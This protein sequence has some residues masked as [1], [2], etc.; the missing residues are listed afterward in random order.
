[1]AVIAQRDSAEV[2]G[3]LGQAH[4]LARMVGGGGCRLLAAEN[5]AVDAGNAPDQFKVLLG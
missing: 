1:M 5:F 3:S 2:A 4:A